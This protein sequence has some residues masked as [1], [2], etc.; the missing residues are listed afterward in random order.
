MLASLARLCVAPPTAAVS[1][2][3]VVTWKL[4]SLVMKHLVPALLHSAGRSTIHSAEDRWHVEHAAVLIAFL[5]EVRS[6]IVR[7]N[8]PFANL[9]DASI[10]S[11]GFTL[12]TL[13]DAAGNSS[14]HAS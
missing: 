2:P 7:V 10:L 1:P 13:T 4:A 9:T 6:A 11:P 3:I 8:L 12:N 5:R 14:Y